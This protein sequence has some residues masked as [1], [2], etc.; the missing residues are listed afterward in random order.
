M[1]KFSFVSLILF[2]CLPPATA[3]STDSQA[4]QTEALAR[5]L[6]K[7]LVEI[8]TTHAHGSTEAA[9]VLA[10][11]FLAAGFAPQDVALLVPTDHPTKGNLGNDQAIFCAAR[12]ARTGTSTGRYAGDK[13]WEHR[14]GCDRSDVRSRRDEHHA[15]HH[16]HGD[17]D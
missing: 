16:L 11:R 15:A 17:H 14:P 4:T 10:G 13:P 6:L 5:D 12:G 8:N 1:N 3:I 2:A 9:K 7:Q